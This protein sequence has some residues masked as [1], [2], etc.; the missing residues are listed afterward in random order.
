[1]LCMKR[2]LVLIIGII[3]QTLVYSQN[4]SPD[5]VSSSGDYF[6]NA[7]NSLSWTLGENIIETVSGPNNILTQGFQQTNYI[8][9]SINENSSDDYSIV[10]YPNPANELVELK[11]NSK[12][13]ANVTADLY[14]GNA[15]LLY[16]KIFKDHLQIDL[17][18]YVSGNYFIRV[19]DKE[20]HLIR[21]FKI[22]KIN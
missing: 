13:L 21:S 20:R 11:A 14:D 10:A 7:N 9:T 4:L 1:M 5:V 22:Q 17:K 18:N 15:N 6:T 19:S 16:S 3:W 8:I 2:I 12:E